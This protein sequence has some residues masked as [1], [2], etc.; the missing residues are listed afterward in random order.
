MSKI[1]RIVVLCFWEFPIG[2]APT[3]R[4]LAYSKGLIENGVDVEI[5]SFKR[6]YSDEVKS[7]KI[8]SRGV[9]DGINYEYPHFFNHLGRKLSFVRYYDEIILRSKIFFKILQLKKAK[10]IDF[11][12]FSFD[13]IFSLKAYT[14]LIK[15]LKIPIV[16]VADEYPIPIRD[17]MQNSVPE[18]MIVKY[19]KYHKMFIAR[20]LMSTALKNYYNQKVHP[21]PT[22]I[23]NSIVNTKRFDNTKKIES[24]ND[25][26]CYMGNLALSKD[27][28]DNIIEAFA[29]IAPEFK[30]LE[31]HLYGIPNDHDKKVLVELVKKLNLKEKVFFKGQ[32]DSNLVPEI[33][34]NAKILVNSQPI[35]KRAEGG[36]PTK[37]AEYLMTGVPSLFTDSGEISLYLKDGV[38]GYLVEPCNPNLYAAKMKYILT[39]YANAKNVASSGKIHVTDNF[40]SKKVTKQL[41]KFLEE[42]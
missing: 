42:H 32:V 21:L 13:D 39:D 6:I 17:F 3:N 14:L 30:D 16:F 35:T 11:I 29:L 24:R 20:I 27:N 19:R 38:H 8:H 34:C 18:N 36:F 7:N 40:N 22:F 4:I 31:L 37:L 12:F 28:V 33:L 10:K 9:V 1:K 23:L 41:L 5:V 25:Y 15:L 26:I 2:M